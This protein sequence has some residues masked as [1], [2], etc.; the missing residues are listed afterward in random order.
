MRIVGWKR[1]S[2]RRRRSCRSGPLRCE[3]GT[4]RCDGGSLGVFHAASREIVEYSGFS[5]LWGAA[6]LD[7]FVD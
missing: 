1:P 5:A 2:R 6:V 4:L 3:W 7:V